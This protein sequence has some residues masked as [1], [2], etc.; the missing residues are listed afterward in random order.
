VRKFIGLSLAASVAILA[1]GLNALAAD[2][3][4]K[5]VPIVA[6]NYDWSGVYI[7]AH[8]GYGGGMKDWDDQSADFAAGGFLAGGQVGINKQV[9]SFV[10]GLELDGSW[11]DIKGSQTLLVAN[12]LVQTTTSKIDGLVTFA[13][14]AG[15]AADRWFVFA[16]AGLAAAH[17][18][19]SLNFV[20]TGITRTQNGNEVRLAPMIGFGTEYALGGN[21]SVK[22]EYDYF[23]LGTRTVALRGTQTVN[24][25]AAPAPLDAGIDQAIHVA[26]IGVNY[27]LGSVATDPGYAPVRPAPGTNWSGGYV[28]VQTGYGWGQK[29]WP[30]IFGAPVW[31]SFDMKGWLGGAS[32]GA[33]AQA[34]VFVFGVEGE[35]MGGDITGRGTTVFNTFGAVQTVVL[36]SKIDWLALATA[37]AGF[38]VGDR[39]MLYG[40]GGVAI[41]SEK[42]T[43]NTAVIGTDFS[44]LENFAGKAVHTGV[45]VGAGSEYALGNNWSVKLEYDYIRMFQQQLIAFGPETANGTSFASF[46]TFSKLNQDLHLL[47][48][49][50]NYHFSPLPVVVARY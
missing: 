41:A 16:K 36:D 27:R 5:A 22:G 12:T 8:A 7:G 34:G 38:V 17:E 10:F 44:I 2:M 6:A 21:W 37:R 43:M 1:G 30:N 48:V 18:T 40:K 31:P 45:V 14:R 39:L 47:K 42:H 20:N 9:A 50:V 26:K 49:G 46:G 11:A 25:I 28:G 24:G 3:P 19:H 35:I 29:E 33:N 32:I 15:L 4:V 13:G 23:H